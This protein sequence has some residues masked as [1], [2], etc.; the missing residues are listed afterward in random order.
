M[1]IEIIKSF[2]RATR[3]DLS[4]DAVKKIYFERLEPGETF[5]SLA[6]S[7]E[8]GKFTEGYLRLMNG[9]YPDGEAEPGTYIKLV[10]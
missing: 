4:P 7:K 5:A 9:Y 10:K 8:L 3:Q 1:F 6:A 2:R